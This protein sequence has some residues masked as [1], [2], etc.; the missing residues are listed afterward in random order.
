MEWWPSTRDKEVET[1][2]PLHTFGRNSREFSNTTLF[3]EPQLALLNQRAGF[4]AKGAA[5]DSKSPRTSF[6]ISLVEPTLHRH[7]SA[8]S[9]L[10]P[11]VPSSI[12]LL[13]TADPRILVVQAWSSISQ[14]CRW[15]RAWAP[16]CGPRWRWLLLFTSEVGGLNECI[17][18]V[19]SQVW[20]SQRGH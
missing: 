20:L 2:P 15:V 5:V 10:G 17:T 16:G 9:A 6:T 13:L 7:A 12:P 3:A 1:P 19:R 11:R 4:W 14:A 8:V 18:T